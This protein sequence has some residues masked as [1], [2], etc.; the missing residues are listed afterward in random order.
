MVGKAKPGDIKVGVIGYGG[1]FNMGKVHLDEMRQAGM[2]PTAV[3][4][5]DPQRLKAA[6]QDF[7]G[8]ETYASVGRMLRRSGVD[9]LA[10]ITPH[11]THVRLALQ[12][13]QAGR[14][15]VC[16]KPFAITTAQCD[17]MI[18]LARRKGL[19]LSTYHNRHWDGCILQA[20]RTIRSGAIGQVFRLEAHMGSWGQ[21][22]DWWRSSKSISGG[23]LYDWGVH[24]LEYTF[25]IIPAGIVE[26]TGLSKKGF[27]AAK[28]RWK[29]DTNEDEG[30]LL[31]R[32]DNG[33]WSTLS[34]SSLESR[35]KPGWVEVTGTL[36]SYLFDYHTYELT[37]HKG[38]ATVI[39]K[40]RNPPSR[41]G[42]FYRNIA[43]HLTNGARLVITPEWARRPVHVLDLACQ[44]AAKGRAL[45]AKYH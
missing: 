37:T 11:N 12:C 34:I 8:I 20:V 26:V 32:Y 35:A 10:I 31:V 30:F 27:W 38:G 33:A 18:S 40:G 25:Q 28:T 14:H 1:A 24:L 16:E 13:L 45:P 44:S 9:L 41:H 5:I 7:P 22:G 39:T 15:V 17:A 3:A 43:D 36:G 6:R 21:P 29:Q 42:R 23:I 4:D 2:N 19:L